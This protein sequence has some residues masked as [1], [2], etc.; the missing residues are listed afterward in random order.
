LLDADPS[1]VGWREREAKRQ[2]DKG[3]GPRT[4]AEQAEHQA[5]VDRYLA[6]ARGETSPDGRSSPIRSDCMNLGTRLR[7]LESGQPGNRCPDCGGMPAFGTGVFTIDA[8]GQYD[9]PDDCPT[10]GRPLVF[11][12][13]LDRADPFGDDD[14][15][16]S[17]A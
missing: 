8:T 9:G 15:M 7:R 3:Y 4:S 12:I 16:K 1:L 11:T 17:N 14:D 2:A 5:V 10:C 6:Q 13:T